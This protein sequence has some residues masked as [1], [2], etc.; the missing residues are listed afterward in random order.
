MFNE[1]ITE[2]SI[3]KG[4]ND[5]NII[6]EIDYKSIT[7]TNYDD[8]IKRKDELRNTNFSDRIK[9]TLFYSLYKYDPTNKDIYIDLES[10]INLLFHYFNYKGSINIHDDFIDEMTVLY[11]ENKLSKMSYSEY[12]AFEKEWVSKRYTEEE[13]FEEEFGKGLDE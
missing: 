5:E 12:I 1:K 13:L 2:S 6:D 11:K 3:L 8:Y 10:F 4:G 9:I 7:V